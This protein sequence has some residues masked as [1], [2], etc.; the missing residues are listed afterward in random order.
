MSKKHKI[1]TFILAFITFIVSTF[2][3]SILIIN[4]DKFLRSFNIISV[5]NIST[6][7]NVKFENVKAASEYEIIVYN[8][9]NEILFNTKSD[10]NEVNMNLDKIQYNEKYKIVIFA[11]DDLGNSVSV[12]NP[13]EFT[14]T[15]P[16]FSNLNN[17]VLDNNED[18]NLIIDGNV[19]NKDYYISILDGDKEVVK[20]KLV[21]NDYVIKE[22]YFNDKNIVLTAK[23]YDGVNEINRIDLYSNIS[24]IGNIKIDNPVNESILDYNDVAFNFSGGENATEY[25]LEI[26]KDKRLI[27]STELNDNRAI[28]SSE[29]FEKDKSYDIRIIAKYLDYNNY[30]KDAIVSFKMNEKETLLPAYIN[31]SSNYVKSG[32]FI[33]LSNPNKDGKIYYTID[34]SEPSELSNLYTEPIKVDNNMVIKT[35]IKEDK[36]NDSSISTFN[37]NVGTKKE[38]RVYLSPSNQTGNLGVKEVGYTNESKEMNDLTN[39]IEKRLEEYNVKVYRNNPSGNINL[40]VADSRYFN[41]DLHLAIHSNG[42]VDHQSKGIETW[43]N[44]LNSDTYSLANLIQKDLYDIYYDKENGNRGVKYSNGALGETRMPSFGILVEIAHHDYY[45]DAKW[46]MENKELIGNTIANSILKYYGIIE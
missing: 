37:I 33:K 36:K 42:S 13:Y 1:K 11:Y 21:T 18:Y 24:P 16:T 4:G 34:G 43:I 14:Y 27:K 8:S 44:D 30:S 29:F 45:D 10:N 35:I 22:E 17:L 38:Y 20:E 25:T 9:D 3:C 6:K 28:I 26:Y 12:K 23:L 15:E 46:I 2:V 41:S 40:W 5:S 19:E 32:S 7:Y 31:V 39:Y